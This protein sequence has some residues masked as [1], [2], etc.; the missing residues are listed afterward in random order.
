MIQ[1]QSFFKKILN[2]FSLSFQESADFLEN[3]HKFQ[4]DRIA[5]KEQEFKRDPVTFLGKREV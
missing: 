3:G 2:I 4:Y 1:P 5:D